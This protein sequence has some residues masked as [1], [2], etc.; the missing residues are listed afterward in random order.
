MTEQT[1]SDATNKQ[2]NLNSN[3]NFFVDTVNHISNNLSE[4]IQLKQLQF[5]RGLD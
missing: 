3:G 2:I 4:L 1:E 5:P